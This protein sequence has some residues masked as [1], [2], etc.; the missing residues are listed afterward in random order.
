[1]RD[2][3]L[4][5]LAEAAVVTELP[6]PHSG[7][8]DQGYAD[9]G[10]Y[11]LRQ[12]DVLIAVWDGKPPKIGGTGA[13]AREAFTG[14]IPV[15]WLSTVEDAPPRLITRFSDD[16]APTASSADCTKSELQAALIPIFAA[17]AA[18]SHDEPDSAG[19]GLARYNSETWR[20]IRH[21]A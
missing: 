14:G 17:P 21:S 13:I 4:K 18:A 11:M 8:R 1:M 5:S 12:I 2:E 20:S 7:N 6:Y 3:F 15:V 16:G 9:S 19:A 10:G